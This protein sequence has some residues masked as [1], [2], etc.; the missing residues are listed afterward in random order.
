MH[1]YHVGHSSYSTNK[2]S[3][4]LKNILHVPIATRNLVSVHK[5]ALDNN[6][7][8]EFHPFFFLVKD[9]IT[10]EPLLKGACKGG[11]YSFPSSHKQ[12]LASFKPSSEE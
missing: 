3:S 6:V 7:L 5:L 2:N 1:I 12:A 9:Q 11:L 10:K 4:H 8:L